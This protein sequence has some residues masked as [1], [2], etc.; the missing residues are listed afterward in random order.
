MGNKNNVKKYPPIPKERIE[1]Y[2][3]LW[4]NSTSREGV[5][6]DV[7]AHLERVKSMGDGKGIEFIS[8]L[9]KEYLGA[10]MAPFSQNLKDADIVVIGM[11]FEKSAPMNPSQRYG[12]KALRELSKNF[13]GTTEPWINGEF[14]IPF[15]FANIIDYGTIDTYGKL[16][17]SSEMEYALNH[18]R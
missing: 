4:K 16:D 7:K 18:F 12:P 15:D 9:N 2:Q 3:D 13:M 17:L 6:P 5:H 8:G 1:K 11:P 10:F 14:D